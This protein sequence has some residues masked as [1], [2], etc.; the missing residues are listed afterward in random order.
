MLTRRLLL[1]SAFATV[2]TALGRRSL[3]AGPAAGRRLIVV[4]NPGGWDPLSCVA[5]MYDAPGVV[6]AP[7][8]GPATAGGLDYV[9]LGAPAVRDF[10]DAWH[11]RTLVLRG[12]SVPSVS[13]DI[14][15]RLMLTGRVG[16]DRP[17]WP[18]LVG[19]AA[20]D[21]YTVP[22]LVLGG[23]SFPGEAGSSSA[24]VGANGQLQRLLDGSIFD[25][26]DQPISP[27]RSS[28]SRL[29][30]RYAL[31]RTAARADHGGDGVGAGLLRAWD[32]AVRR[33][34]DLKSASFDLSFDAVYDLDGQLALATDL[35]ARGLSRCA[36]V[37]SGQ[38]GTWDTHQ[39]NDAGQAAMLNPLFAALD[40]LMTRLSTTPGP[41]G[42]PLIDS[43][44]V[45][46]ASEF[47]RTPAYNS[48]Q[49]RDHWPFT[50]AL[51]LGAGVAGDRVVGG[52]D[53][54]YF[55]AP[56][57]LPSG[58]VSAAGTTP[59]VDHLGATLLALADVDPGDWLPGVEPIGGV[60]A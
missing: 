50:S 51:L 60:L 55:G 14:A 20:A 33:A 54:V 36:S 23:P 38:L 25:S 30:D 45:L 2:A 49:G 13:H 26:S 16:A 21:A 17:D 39:N 59:S 35:L 27:L 11:S 5:P 56:I 58:E 46:V 44:T 28:T 10:F 18:S 41:D 43:T 40:R 24:R 32:T 52:Y 22:S 34:S 3:S 31:A 37:S 7:G 12:L 29:L 9:D 53:D 57:D 47:G 4:F 48:N 6:M 19:D 1:G 8:S 15:T 42:A